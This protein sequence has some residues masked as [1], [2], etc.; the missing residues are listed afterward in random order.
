MQIIFFDCPGKARQTFG[1]PSAKWRTFAFRELEAFAMA[2]G[3]EMHFATMVDAQL[4]G[5]NMS[6]FDFL[7]SSFAGTI[8]SGT[9]LPAS[10]CTLSDGNL[11]YCRLP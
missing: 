1:K 5:A 8:D 7:N 4:E 6:D 2:Q 10:G 3:A 9:E 11:V